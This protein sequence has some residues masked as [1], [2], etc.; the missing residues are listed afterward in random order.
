MRYAI[1][2]LYILLYIRIF[3]S[4]DTFCIRGRFFF[5]FLNCWFRK[6][7]WG[8]LLSILVFVLFFANPPAHLTASPLCV[9]CA[10]SY[11]VLQWNKLL[12]NKNKCVYQLY[13]IVIAWLYD[14]DCLFLLYYIVVTHEK[15]RGYFLGL[16]F[17]SV[18]EEGVVMTF[19]LEWRNAFFRVLMKIDIIKKKID[20]FFFKN[21]Y[22]CTSNNSKTV[23]WSRRTETEIVVCKKCQRKHSVDV[24]DSS[25]TNEC[26]EL[27]N[28]HAYSFLG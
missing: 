25:Y 26:R 17:L 19:L 3:L 12:K 21:Y 1:T 24:D 10:T 11:M 22:Y 28:L 13:E 18:M 15:K 8:S 20:D 2:T 27:S 16:Y 9:W 5:F 7:L 4:I 14:I 23:Y 6:N